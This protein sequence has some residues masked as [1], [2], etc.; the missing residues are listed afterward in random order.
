[1]VKS[2]KIQP[3]EQDKLGL[4]PLLFAIDA[5]LD[6]DS[7]K[8]LVSEGGCDVRQTDAEGDSALHYAVNLDNKQLEKWLIETVGEEFRQ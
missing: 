7:I 8:K 5:S 1:M 3:S 6:L 2:G 4:N